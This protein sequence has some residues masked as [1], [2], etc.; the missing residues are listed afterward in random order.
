M[1]SVVSAGWLFGSYTVLRWN[2]LARMTLLRRVLLTS[3]VS[4]VALALM[5]QI[6]NPSD[7]VWLLH[8]S[9]QVVI[10]SGL[11]LWSVL[12]RLVLR[13]GILIPSAPRCVLVG[14]EYERAILCDAWR[15]TPRV[16]PFNCFPLPML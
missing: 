4:A 1:G 2:R 7:A 10:F 13:R 5:R 6:F 12:M 9:T 14:D 3:V 8:R 16:S 15:L 11:T